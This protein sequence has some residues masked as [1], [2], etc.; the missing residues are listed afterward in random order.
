[1]EENKSHGEIQSKTV[2]LQDNDGV[3]DMLSSLNVGREKMEKEKKRKQR[4]KI[5]IIF[6]GSILTIGIVIAA[7]YV[8]L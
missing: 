5:I 7:V 6:A 2:L 1:M 4:N 3:N 8:V